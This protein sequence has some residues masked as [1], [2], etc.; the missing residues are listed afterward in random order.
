MIKAAPDI[1]VEVLSHRDELTREQRRK[2][3]RR[4]AEA[5]LA[6]EAVHSSAAIFIYAS[7]RSEV[8]TLP[9]IAELLKRGKVVTVPLTRVEQKRLDIVRI[10]NPET[11]LVPGYCS[12]PEPHA[13]LAA[14]ATVPAAELDLIVLPGSVFDVRGG[15]YGYGGGY[16]DRLLAE[17]PEVLRCGLA[18]ELQIREKIDLQPH[19]QLLDCIVTEKRIISPPFRNSPGGNK[20]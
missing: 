18:Y 2:K 19:D 4:I 3:S 11:D 10:K 17:V 16:Y 14:A 20:K 1:R 5:L 15:R 6:S 8:E 9:I 12:I 13:E 7:F